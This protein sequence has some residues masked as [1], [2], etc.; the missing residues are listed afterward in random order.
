MEAQNGF[1]K[2]NRDRRQT[3]TPCVMQTLCW[4]QTNISSRQELT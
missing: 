2:E 1:G 4:P 3:K